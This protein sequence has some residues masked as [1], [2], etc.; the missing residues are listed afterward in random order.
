MG[1]RNLVVYLFT[2]RMRGLC[3]VGC[4]G[5]MKLINGSGA[6]PYIPVPSCHA[7]SEYVLW[8]SVALL[9]EVCFNL[10]EHRVQPTLPPSLVFQCKP[11]PV[12]RHSGCFADCRSGHQRL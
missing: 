7:F 11:Q 8:K 4:V 1:G 5:Q 9:L 2:L 6:T 12:P 3:F 10:I